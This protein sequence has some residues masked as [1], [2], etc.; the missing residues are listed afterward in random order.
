MSCAPRALSP[1]VDALSRA[2]RG[3]ALLAAVCA[4]CVGCST[5]RA[6]GRAIVS[7]VSKLVG[8]EPDCEDTPHVVPP[9]AAVTK[10]LRIGSWNMHYLGPSEETPDER[11]DPR[12]LAAYIRAGGASVLALQEIGVASPDDARSATLDRVFDLLRADGAD[13]TYRLYGDAEDPS[14]CVGLAWD[15]R[16]VTSVARVAFPLEQR[17]PG[18]LDPIVEG[19]GL[20]LEP[21]PRSRRAFAVK[22][23]GGPGSTDLVLLP[24]HLTARV[25][26]S[27]FQD[28]TAKREA[29][30]EALAE[31]LG[32]V[33]EALRDRDLVV[34]GDFNTEFGTEGV[35]EE[36]LDRGWRDLNC[37]DVT[38]Y[39][40][41]PFPLDRVFVPRDQP[42]FAM[43]P[44][45]ALVSP[46]GMD[47]EEFHE[48]CSDHF[49][50]VADVLVTRDDD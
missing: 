4:A 47:T 20:P 9:P 5:F 10:K 42:E 50:V 41:G 13:W 21:D 33:M 22:L 40:D 29:Q 37:S 44:D 32:S 2:A 27:L 28:A 11:R 8:A 43:D 14:Q 36:L 46:V 7:P 25:E 12:D 16:V 39:L 49:M 23:S 24:V 45:F 31:R 19:V 6:V 18:L 48:R 3:A 15:R 34:L 1:P 30:A 26:T 38:T 35:S 17:T